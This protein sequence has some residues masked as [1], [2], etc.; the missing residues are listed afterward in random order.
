MCQLNEKK[1]APE[2]STA[3]RHEDFLDDACIGK[4][5]KHCDSGNYNFKLKPIAVAFVISPHKLTISRRFV[6]LTVAGTLVDISRSPSD[7]CPVFMLLDT[8]SKLGW[9]QSREGNEKLGHDPV[10]PGK[11]NRLI[12]GLGTQVV[13]VNNVDRS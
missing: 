6:R 3:R 5:L 1:F 11:C 7:I 12:H 2:L 4:A 13:G 9:M 10:I 8:F